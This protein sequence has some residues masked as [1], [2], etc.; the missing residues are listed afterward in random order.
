MD[1]RIFI[2]HFPCLLHSPL[3]LWHLIHEQALKQLNRIYRWAELEMTINAKWKNNWNSRRRKVCEYKIIQFCDS[4]SSFEATKTLKKIIRLTFYFSLL[5]TLFQVLF[6]LFNSSIFPSSIIR[7]D[8][9]IFLYTFTL[10]HNLS[11]YI[12]FKTIKQVK[13]I[14]KWN[15]CRR[16]H[17]RE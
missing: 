14:L 11:Y 1:A 10:F 7:F 15:T 16:H 4:N 8:D 2:H 3:V 17:V 5:S 9:T 13:R 6:E 12:M